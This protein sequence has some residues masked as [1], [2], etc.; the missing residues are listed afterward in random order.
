MVYY[1]N[2]Q[3]PCKKTSRG[4]KSHLRRLTRQASGDSREVCVRQITL[5]RVSTARVIAEKRAVLFLL[6]F[7]WEVN[8]H[9][10]GRIR[11][12]KYSPQTA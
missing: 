6:R 11:K 3:V 7:P 8:N 12:G 4:Q 9:I 5:S 2:K 10:A 1:P